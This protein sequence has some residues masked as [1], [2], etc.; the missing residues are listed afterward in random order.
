MRNIDKLKN[1][2]KRLAEEIRTAKQERKTVNFNGKRTIKNTSKWCTDAL[3]CAEL[4]IKLKKEFRHKHIAYCML[5]GKTLDEIESTTKTTENPYDRKYRD[6]D[7]IDQL[8]TEY[9]WSPEEIEA[10]YERQAKV[11]EVA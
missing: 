5:R 6:M 8:L 2:L 1:E 4:A 9:A 7:Y 11:A 10:Y 3:F